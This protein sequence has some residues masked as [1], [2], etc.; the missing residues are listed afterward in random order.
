MGAGNAVALASAITFATS[1]TLV[2]LIYEAGANVH[3]VNLARAL[4][5][6]GVVAL[7]LALRRVSPALPPR[8]TMQCTLVGLLFCGELYGWWPPSSTYPWVS[9][10]SSCTP[11]H[12]W[13]R[14]PV[15]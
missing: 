7:I 5:F 6:A 8:A 1:I 3:A 2:A 15:G 4:A 13:S 9:R 12:C 10:C 14:S 11:T